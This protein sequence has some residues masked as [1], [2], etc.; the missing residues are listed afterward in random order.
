VVMMMIIYPT[1][2]KMVM[3]RGGS[4]GMPAGG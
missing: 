4:R 3:R 2:K 1:I